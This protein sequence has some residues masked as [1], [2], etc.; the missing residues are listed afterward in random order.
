[1]QLHGAHGVL[2]CTIIIA[3]EFDLVAETIKRALDGLQSRWLAGKALFIFGFGV[4]LEPGADACFIE[5]APG[6]RWPG[7]RFSQYCYV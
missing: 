6:E 5:L 7:V 3:G 2:C 1:M 4:W